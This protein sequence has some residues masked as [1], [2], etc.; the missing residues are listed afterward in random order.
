[1]YKYYI[2][3]KNFISN[4]QELID[5]LEL[6]GNFKNIPD[7]LL[8]KNKLENLKADFYNEDISDNILKEKFNQL[9]NSINNYLI[10][11]SL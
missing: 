4:L 2:T 11:N 1:M 6:E 5:S 3:I 10:E 9:E 7:L 8:Y